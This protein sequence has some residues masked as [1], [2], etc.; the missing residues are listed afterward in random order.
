M[1]GL[2]RRIGSRMSSPSATT[3]GMQDISEMR[4]PVVV[5]D[6]GQ[7]VPTMSWITAATV[8]M[9]WETRA[10]RTLREQLTELT[11]SGR[12]VEVYRGWD[13]DSVPERLKA[14]G[15]PFERRGRKEMQEGKVMMSLVEGYPD[16]PAV[17]YRELP[18]VPPGAN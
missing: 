13:E 10:T 18:P 7:H 14:W 16:F 12:T 2:F 8:R 1:R 9:T 15:I 3:G 6:A 4:G 5:T 11:Q 17:R